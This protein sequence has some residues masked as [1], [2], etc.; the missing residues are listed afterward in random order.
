MAPDTAPDIGGNSGAPIS[1]PARFR[2]NRNTRVPK[3]GA[4][5]AVCPRHQQ[6][7][8]FWVLQLNPKKA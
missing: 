1:G 3:A 4:Q 8:G 2:W 5:W 7:H 6:Q